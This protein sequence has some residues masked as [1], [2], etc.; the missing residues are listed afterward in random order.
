MLQDRWRQLDFSW[1]YPF[2]GRYSKESEHIQIIIWDRRSGKMEN[3]MQK[4]P[5]AYR[6]VRRIGR[7]LCVE[8]VDRK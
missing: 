6:T 7:N 3:W 5:S 1:A 4:S 2:T 8:L